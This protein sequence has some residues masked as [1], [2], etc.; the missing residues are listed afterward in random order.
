MVELLI[1]IPFAEA[2]L[3]LL[4]NWFDE[5]YLKRKCINT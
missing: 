1:L 3:L 5:K 2:F 4:F